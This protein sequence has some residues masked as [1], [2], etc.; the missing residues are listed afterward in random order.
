MKYS[1]YSHQRHFGGFEKKL[2]LKKISGGLNTFSC[3]CKSSDYWLGKIQRC[4][5]TAA[6]ASPY[7]LLPQSQTY[8]KV[9]SNSP[10]DFQ[11]KKYDIS[12]DELEKIFYIPTIYLKLKF[13]VRYVK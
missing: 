2:M 3:A 5:A 11:T 6:A 10:F 1:N 12:C 9:F 8:H 4:S 13:D 7:K